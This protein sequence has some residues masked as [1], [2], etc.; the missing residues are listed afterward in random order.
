MKI[1]EVPQDEG[2]LAK[3]N[4]KELCYAV[5]DQGRY[6]TVPSKGWEAKSLVLAESLEL[7]EERVAATKDAVRRGEVSPLA[8]YMEFHRMDVPLLASYAG[9]HR[10]CVKR[11]FHPRRFQKLRTKTLQRYADVFGITIDQLVAPF[12]AEQS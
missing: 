7:I 12:A 6:T 5:D 3:K 11:H 2:S 10:W 8:Y 1:N 9:I 4:V